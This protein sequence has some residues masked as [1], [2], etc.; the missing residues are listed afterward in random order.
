MKLLLLLTLTTLVVLIKTD[1][2]LVLDNNQFLIYNKVYHK[3]RLAQFS[4]KNDRE[5]GTYE[6]GLNPDQLWTLEPHPSQKGCYY[7]VNE[8]HTRHRITNYKHQLI[9]YDGPH[10]GDQLF[11][12]VPSGKNDGFWYIYSCRYEN[13]RLTKFGVGDKEVGMYSGAKSPDQLWR[14]VPRFK[15]NLFTDQVFHFDNRQGSN[16]IT[17]EVSVTTGIKRS[18]TSTIR[19]KSTF[20]YSIEAS[21]GTAFKLFDFGVTAT[22]EFSMELES[23]FAE[24]SEASWSKTEKIQFIVPPGKNFK[25]MQHALE[26][27]GHFSSDHCTLMTDIKI[28]ESDTAQFDDPDDFIVSRVQ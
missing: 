20:K 10:F 14:L 4:E 28:F 11:K 5:I 27:D 24:T 7:I 21:M 25:V 26:F 8:V 16:P 13:D 12:F 2:T 9:I 3:A 1:D 15:A 17:R 18:T 23:T 19:N 22:T 6:H